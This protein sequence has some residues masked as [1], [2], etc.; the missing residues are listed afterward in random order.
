MFNKAVDNQCCCVSL[1]AGRF[2]AHTGDI[3]IVV[4]HSTFN[5]FLP[6]KK[7]SACYNEMGNDD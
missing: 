4:E 6:L 1:G 3:S 2:S 7:I 5:M